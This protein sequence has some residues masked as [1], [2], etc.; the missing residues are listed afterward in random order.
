MKEAI[1]LGLMAL[2]LSDMAL[3]GI[4]L[5]STCIRI[6]AFQGVLLGLFSVAVNWGF[7]T[8]RVWILAAVSGLLKGVVYPLLL[9]RA[10]SDAG[11]QRE[12]EPYVGPI[13]SVLAGIALFGASVWIGGRL[14]LTGAAEAGS[15]L[16]VSASLM[17][18]LTGLF[19]VAARKK[20]LTQT[21]GYIVFENGIFAFGVASVG[22]IPALVELG[23]LLDAFVAVFVMGIAMYHINREFDHLDA[24]RLNALKG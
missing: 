20:A 18:L 2:V 22:E 21:L 23:I 11:V 3:L 5:L 7:L 10:V 16:I 19:L 14:P 13:P 15:R 12:I 24:D 9:R 17:T 4:G 6:V 1:E 8:P